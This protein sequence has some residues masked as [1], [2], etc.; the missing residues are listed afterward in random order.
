M[1]L[2]ILYPDEGQISVLGNQHGSVVNDRIGYLPEERGLY[3]R[4][5]VRDVLEFYAKLK[6]V[7]RPCPAITEWLERMELADWTLKLVDQLSKGMAQKVQFISA[8]VAKPEILILDEPFSGL[9][10]VNHEVLK[11]AIL[12]VRRRG[13]TVVL[14]THSMEVAEKMCDLI[15]MIFRGKKVLDGTLQQI[16]ARYGTDTIRVRVTDSDAIQHGLP[17]V[18]RVNDYGGCHELRTEPTANPQD[19]L[20]APIDRT[21]VIQFEV[22]TP[23]LHDIF[24]RIAGP[25]AIQAEPQHA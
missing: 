2:R 5:R 22:T 3:R 8:I 1:I 18:I 20:R 16:Q 12:E 6:G 13:T 25:D 21:E 19:I 7:R 23:S 10:P 24:V 4:M 17:G 9:D 15:F 11:D 14:S